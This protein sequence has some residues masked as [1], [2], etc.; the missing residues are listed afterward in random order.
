MINKLVKLKYN[1]EA[2]FRK[3]ELR[4]WKDKRLVMVQLSSCP[5]FYWKMQTFILLFYKVPHA[6]YLRV[7]ILVILLLFIAMDNANNLS[8]SVNSSSHP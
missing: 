3:V 2:D 8:E 5:K 7:G 4:V 1:L 6:L